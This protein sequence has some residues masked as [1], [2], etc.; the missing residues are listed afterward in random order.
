M[1]FPLRL[2][3]LFILF[4][5]FSNAQVRGLITDEV[6]RPMPFVNIY[7]ENADGNYEYNTDGF[8]SSERKNNSDFFVEFSFLMV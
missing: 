7:I 1:P 3:V 6:N 4:V 5:N 8:I 2:L